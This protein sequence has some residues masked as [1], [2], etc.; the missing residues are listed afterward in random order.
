[1]NAAGSE[2]A[3]GL[4]GESVAGRRVCRARMRRGAAAWLAAVL[5]FSGADQVCAAPLADGVRVQVRA[6]RVTGNTLLKPSVLHAVLAP[7]HGLRDL[8]QIKAAAAALAARYVEAGYGGVIVTVPPQQSGDG[9]IELAVLE[10]R[11]SKIVVLDNK[12]DPERRIRASLPDV[13]PGITPRPGLIDREM[14]L[15]NLNP[16]RQL[17]MTL[18]PGTA[19][20]DIDARISV[21]EL[22]QRTWTL[23]LD[24]TGNSATGRLRANFGLTQSNLFGHDHT[25]QLGGQIAPEKP[26][27]VAVISGGWRVPIYSLGTLF[28][29][30]GAYSDIDAGTTGTAV[31]PLQFRGKGHTVGV[32]LGKL[33]PRVGDFSQRVSV[34]YDYRAYLNEC[35]ITG[36]PTGACG[37]AGASVSVSPASVDY[38][39]QRGG[40]NPMSFQFGYF[41]NTALIGPHSDLA[42]LSAARPNAKVYFIGERINAQ[43]L[44]QL[45]KDW[46]LQFRVA[47]QSTRSALVPG[48]QFGIAGAGAVRGYEQREVTGD[49]A[50]QGTI[51][52]RTR[53]LANWQPEWFDHLQFVGFF[54]AGRVRNNFDT[55]CRA[56]QSDC[57]LM[58]VGPGL[59]V[60]KR[61]LQL[62]LDLATALKDGNLTKRNDQF[63]HMQASYEFR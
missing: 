32:R 31:G 2:H 23:G 7:Y 22:P 58:S 42:A 33:L 25:L 41:A 54:D 20:G 9:D 62:R 19:R 57:S 5:A 34:G 46:Q 26:D 55:P 39:L 61:D 8:K 29:L 36:L 4:Y 49:Q 17:A 27:K 28:D 18:E 38:L 50:F 52:L 63:L 11:F 6:F 30:F 44:F 47:G 12:R 48:E 3:V 13:R 1:M 40:A 51:E 56:D 16:A 21:T 43:A 45:P 35:S 60:A 53:D 24:N 15:A 14:Q 37:T 59:R 10:G